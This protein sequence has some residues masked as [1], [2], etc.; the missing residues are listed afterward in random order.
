[1]DWDWQM[2]LGRQREVIFFFRF[3]FLI[4][5][6]RGDLFVYFI[7]LNLFASLVFILRDA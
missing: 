4:Q 2:C 6:L 1:M 7:G 3:F 5:G